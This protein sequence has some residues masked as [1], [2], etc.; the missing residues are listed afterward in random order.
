MDPAVQI[1]KSIFEPS[2]IL[3]PRYAVYSRCSFPLQ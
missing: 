1:T 3:L 2:L